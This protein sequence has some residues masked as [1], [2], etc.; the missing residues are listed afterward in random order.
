MGREGRKERRKEGEKKVCECAHSSLFSCLGFSSTIS[1][2]PLSLPPYLGVFLDVLLC[3]LYGLP[4]LLTGGLWR[5]EG[6]R[7]VRREG[8]RR[9][10]YGRDDDRG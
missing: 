3:P 6:R 9:S 8:G 4:T 7:E 1:P 10:Q 5:E 2:L